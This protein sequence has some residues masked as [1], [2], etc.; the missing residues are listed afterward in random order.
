MYPEI[1]PF[2]HGL[3]DAGDANQIYWEVCGNPNG[4]PVVVLHGG[5]GSGCNSGMR[6][7]FQP[8][9]YRIVLF[10]QRG[11][12][13]S[14]PP[15]SEFTTDLSTNT[16]AHLLQDLERLRTFLRIER[17]MIFG[18]SWGCTLGIAYA[19]AYPERVSE[20][21]FSGVTT[22]RRSEIR[23]LYHDIAPLFP[24]EWA[25]F[26]GGVPRS[27]QDG[28]L[29]AAYY[30]LL[31]SP[32]SAVRDQAARDWCRWEA[33][34]LSTDPNYKPSAR[35]FDPK[36]QRAFSRVV[37]HY[38]HHGAWLKEGILLQNAHRLKGI[39]GVLVHGRLDLDAPLTTAWELSQRWE[40]SELVIVFGA[41]HSP[42]DPGMTEAIL[43]ATD[44]FSRLPLR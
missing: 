17:W 39:P 8:D 44:R 11:S 19:E 26:R 43:E 23:W 41:G 27:E 38:F 5:P 9:L 10:D 28:D 33:S 24:A 14:L 20:M 15:A 7:L 29:V 2:A 31:Q 18:G 37:T 32:D 3:L 6:R 1:E 34:L 4:K 22:T 12:G 36:F 16:T 30:R 13:R 35:W 21:V 42:S 25:K 40:G